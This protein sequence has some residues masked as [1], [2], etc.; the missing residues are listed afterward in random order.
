MRRKAQI[1]VQFIKREESG[2]ITVA[3][4]QVY[5]EFIS[6]TAAALV[7]VRQV[8]TDVLAAVIHHSTRVLSYKG[9]DIRGNIKKM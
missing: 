1:K 9:G 5:G 2:I 6:W 4:L 3:C 8:C 7:A